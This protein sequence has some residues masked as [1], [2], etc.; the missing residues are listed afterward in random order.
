MQPEYEK[1]PYKIAA[2]KLNMELY[3]QLTGNRSIPLSKEYWTL[4][5]E[6]TTSDDSEI[7]QLVNAGFLIKNQ[8]CGVDRDKDKK[9]RSLGIIDRNKARHPEARWER[10]DWLSVIESPVIPFN[11]AMIY[12][13]STSFVDTIRAADL[14]VRTMLRCQPKTLLLSNFILNNPRGKQHFD[15]YKLIE[16][17]AMQ[18]PSREFQTWKKEICNYNYC[19]TGITK[20]KTFVWFKESI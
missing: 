3:F 2:R 14:T 13:D 5:N 17:I 7:M 1:L 4:C 8:F 16:N 12:L 19:A 6:Q 11:P 18:M 10:G 15:P 20:L 9:G